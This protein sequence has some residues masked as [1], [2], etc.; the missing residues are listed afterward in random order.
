MTAKTLSSKTRGI[1]WSVSNVPLT[2]AMEEAI[3]ITRR[4]KAAIIFEGNKH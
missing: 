3:A 2:P 4:G 1:V